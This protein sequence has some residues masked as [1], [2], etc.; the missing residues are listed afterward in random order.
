M[1][2][3][4]L[5]I[6]VVQGKTKQKAMSWMTPSWTRTVRFS[7]YSTSINIGVCVLVC[8]ARLPCVKKC[9]SMERLPLRSKFFQDSQRICTQTK[10]W[11]ILPYRWVRHYEKMCYRGQNKTSSVWRSMPAWFLVKVIIDILSSF[12]STTVQFDFSWNIHACAPK[13]SNKLTEISTQTAGNQKAVYRAFCQAK[14]NRKRISA[15][16]FDR[17]KW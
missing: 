6:K 3:G 5:L 9:S 4:S 14:S 11:S 13:L 17:Y 10:L 2:F 7:K 15:S 16:V 12:R 8:Y 1:E